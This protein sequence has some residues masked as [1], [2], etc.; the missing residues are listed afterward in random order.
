M[1]TVQKYDKVLF[2]I[3]IPLYFYF[4]IHDRDPQILNRRRFQV[5]D[6]AGENKVRT[7]KASDPSEFISPSWLVVNL[8]NIIIDKTK[9]SF[10][11]TISTKL[12][13]LLLFGLFPPFYFDF[14][15]SYISSLHCLSK[16]F[17]ETLYSPGICLTLQC[18]AKWNQWFLIMFMFYYI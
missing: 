6:F 3:L 8:K 9:S 11:S 14:P 16:N 1:N 12:S 7:W 15:F 2:N 4:N 10:I 5:E 17:D 18:I 13:L